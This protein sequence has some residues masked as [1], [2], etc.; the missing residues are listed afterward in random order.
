MFLTERLAALIAP[1][2]CLLCASEGDILC[3][4]CRDSALL[5][6]PGCCYLC[7]THV[8][9]GALCVACQCRTPLR[10]VYARSE[11]RDAAKQLMHDFK[12]SHRRGYAKAMATAMDVA[13]PR[14]T[15]NTIVTHVPTATR[16]KRER[17]YDQAALLAQAVAKQLGL[18]YAALLERLGNTRQVGSKRTGRRTQLQGVFRSRRRYMINGSC[19]LLVDDIL[20]TGGTLEAAA[21]VLKQ[22][23]AATI[24]AAVFAQAL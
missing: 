18:P 20:T 15:K 5:P 9:N 3:R 1:P 6:A 13:L 10:A 23:G 4:N 24:D 7:L 8:T 22:A 19:V 14:F 21:T 16:R 2:S 12:F 11:Y 17:G